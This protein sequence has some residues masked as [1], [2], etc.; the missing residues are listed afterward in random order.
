MSIVIENTNLEEL[1]NKFFADAEEQNRNSIL[2]ARRAQRLP[3]L[4]KITE[5]FISNALNLKEFRDQLQSALTRNDELWGTKGPGFTMELNKLIKN[6]D[7]HHPIAEDQLRI[8]LAGINTHNLGER[9]EQ[10]YNF[11]HR[12]K[13]RLNREGKNSNQAMAPGNTAFI[14]SLFTFW[15]NP[16]HPPV[17]YYARTCLSISLL[18]HS[19]L[20]PQSGEL[21]LINDPKYKTKT[22]IICNNSEHL[23][24]QNAIRDLTRRVAAFQKSPS[25]IEHFLYWIVSGLK[26]QNEPSTT[27]IQEI[28]D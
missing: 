4:K 11:L 10:F 9:I 23:V 1:T 16:E 3:I 18:I 8:T 26:S 19:G 22:I 13:S 25:A 20:L 15:L 6:H 27:L 2:D 21:H 5:S 17:I 12:E 7:E 28:D 14:T 24:F